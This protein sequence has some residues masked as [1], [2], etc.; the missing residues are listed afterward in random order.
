[1][2]FK[3]QL[4]IPQKI[5]IAYVHEY[6]DIHG[7]T[8]SIQPSLVEP[9]RQVETCAPVEALFFPKKQKKK[10][11]NQAQSGRQPLKKWRAQI[12]IYHANFMTHGSM[13]DQPLGH[14]IARRFSG[15]SGREHFGPR[16]I[17]RQHLHGPVTTT[18]CK[19][20]AQY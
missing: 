16:Q 1:M 13:Q 20:Q 14:K 4:R 6:V 9:A 11:Q 19:K 15:A 8:T 2:I 18:K 17:R 10:K 3:K 5:C 12:N 7:R